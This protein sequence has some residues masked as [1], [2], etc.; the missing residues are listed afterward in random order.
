MAPALQLPQRVAIL[1]HP[2]LLLLEAP[3]LVVMAVQPPMPAGLALQVAMLP[4]EM[5]QPLPRTVALQQMLVTVQQVP[6]AQPAVTAMVVQVLAV[7]LV[8]QA[9]LVKA[10]WVGLVPWA[11]VPWAVSAVTAV[12][13]W[14]MRACSTCPTP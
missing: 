13:S 5:P 1:A 12:G 3:R 6:A 7:P 14:L 9:A 4:T 8:L 10:D 11:M 2:R